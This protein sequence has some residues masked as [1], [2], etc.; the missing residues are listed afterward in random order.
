M[1]HEGKPCVK[2]S[3]THALLP[4]PT[5]PSPCPPPPPRGQCRFDVALQAK[6]PRAGQAGTSMA[7]YTVRLLYAGTMPVVLQVTVP[8]LN[9]NLPLTLRCLMQSLFATFRLSPI[10]LIR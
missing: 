1:R 6:T 2:S 4:V 7:T 5:D 9:I 8:L 10:V 3:P